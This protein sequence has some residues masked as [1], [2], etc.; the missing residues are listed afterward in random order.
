MPIP[1]ARAADVAFEGAP[2]MFTA[3]RALPRTASP[4]VLIVGRQELH[5]LDEQGFVTR[6][7]G[8]GSTVS[9]V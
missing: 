6:V 5:D 1:I 9:P 7:S 4:V 3:N 8:L 2:V